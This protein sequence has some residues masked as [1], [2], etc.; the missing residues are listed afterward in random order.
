V[1]KDSRSSGYNFGLNDV[2]LERVPTVSSSGSTQPKNP[3]SSKSESRVPS[4]GTPVYRGLPLS[5]YL[6]QLEHSSA[7]DRADIVRSIGAFGKDGASAVRYVGNALG[8]ND[9]DVKIAAAWT[10]SQLGPEAAPAVPALEK[11]LTDADANV[12]SLSAVA[13]RSMGLS[14]KDAIPALISA[15]KDPAAYVRAPAAE[16]LGRMG[17]SAKIAVKPLSESL[18]ASGEETF[19][20]RSVATALGNIGPEAAGGIPAL[21]RAMSLHRVTGSAQE[22]ILKI[23]REP[24][25]TW[26]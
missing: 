6:Q 1:G 11:S 8:D 20:L 15:L 3:A 19:V 7:N 4:N 10:L 18:L 21:Q 17:A 22:A 14:A 13:L 2:V 5:A 25:Q 16:A 23:N 26:Y 9:V 12:R 24:V